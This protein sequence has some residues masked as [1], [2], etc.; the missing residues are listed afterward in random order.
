VA[1][2]R[3]APARAGRFQRLVSRLELLP[4]PD[5]PRPDPLLERP[6]PLLLFCDDPWLRLPPLSRLLSDWLR[7]FPLPRD[8]LPGP[9]DLFDW[10]AMALLLMSCGDAPCGAFV[11][12]ARAQK[13]FTG[14]PLGRVVSERRHPQIRKEHIMAKSKGGS[15]RAQPLAIELLL[16]DHRKVEDLF[17]QYEGEK[18]GDEGTRRE[19]AQQ[20]CAELTVHAQVEEELFYPWLREQLEDEDMEMVEEAQVEHNSAKDLI[21]QIEGA[22]D[23]DEVF[24][25]KVKVLSEYIKHHVQEEEN[26]IFPEVRGEQEELDELGQEMAARK[27]ELMEEMGLSADAEEEEGEEDDGDRKGRGH[28]SGRESTQRSR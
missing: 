7:D 23:I 4:R 9:D 28:S 22:A 21:A 25:A 2:G 24:N 6:L 15:A 16:A 19:I 12:S 10:F 18:E 3:R 20:I 5:D 13:W 27:G 11:E 8:E 14:N 26:E 1:A 17:E